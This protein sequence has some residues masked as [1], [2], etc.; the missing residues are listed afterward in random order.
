MTKG[1]SPEAGSTG[2]PQL[3]LAIRVA[4]GRAS[5]LE[6]RAWDESGGSSDGLAEAQAELGGCLPM[7]G[8]AEGAEVVE[9]A[10]APAFRHGQDMVG[11]PEGT[12]GGDGLKAVEG[13]AGA[14]GCAP[15]TLERGVDGEGI[16]LAEMTDAAVARED[17]VAEKARIG[18]ETPLEDA[19]VGAEGAASA[20]EDFELA[21]A[22][23]WPSE[24]AEREGVGLDSSAGQGTRREHGSLRIDRGMEMGK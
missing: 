6:E 15:G 22:A 20:G 1:S 17:Q 13:E 11:I 4:S 18:T 19:E 7:A 23:E 24:G 21:P 5:C 3:P 14:A 12:A 8:E 10:L 16:G 9:I 2:W